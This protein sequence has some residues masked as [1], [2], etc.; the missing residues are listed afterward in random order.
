METACVDH[1]EIMVVLIHTMTSH[2]TFIWV[3]Y[4]AQSIK[5]NILWIKKT[6]VC[7]LQSTPQFLEAHMDEYAYYNV[8]LSV[9]LSLIRLF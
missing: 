5:R 6:R 2:P 1:E 3:T 8:D 9:Q 4:M 7:F